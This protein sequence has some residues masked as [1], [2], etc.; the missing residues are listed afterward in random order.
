MTAPL[1]GTCVAFTLVPNG[2]ISARAAINSGFIEST[3]AD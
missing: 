1:G 2:Q 3:D